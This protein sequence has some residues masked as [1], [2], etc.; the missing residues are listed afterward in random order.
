MIVRIEMEYGIEGDLPDTTEE[1][2]KTL[3]NELD[4]VEDVLASIG[5]YMFFQDAELIQEV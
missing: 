1:Y 3:D 5:I 4:R 2:Q